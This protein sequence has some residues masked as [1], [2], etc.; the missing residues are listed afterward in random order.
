MGFNLGAL[1]KDPRALAIGLSAAG[2]VLAINLNT[3]SNF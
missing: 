2:G 3:N 1:L